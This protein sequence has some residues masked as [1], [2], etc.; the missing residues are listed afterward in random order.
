MTTQ[1][2]IP[3]SITMGILIITSCPS[4]QAEESIRL[5][6]KF[7]PGY[8]YH[9][10]TRTELAGTL[11]LP[12][13]KEQ[14]A[15]KTL[16]VTGSSSIEYDENVLTLESNGAVQKSARIYRRMDFQR[17][18]GDKLQQISLRPAVRRLIVLRNNHVEVPFSPDGPLTWGEIDLVRTD[19]FTPA[20]AGLLSEQP[21]KTG[22][23]WPVAKA[24]IRELTDLERIEEGSLE[25]RLDQITTLEKR[26]LARVVFAGSV[27]GINEDGPT[28]QQLD[29]YFFFDLESNHLSYLSLK[30]VHSLLD[31][32]GK[33]V[34]KIEGQFVLSRQAPQASKDLSE[35]AW[36]SVVVEPNAENTLLLYENEDLGVQFLHSR[37]WR[38]GGVQGRQITLD[39]S[40]GSGLM[41][42]VEPAA[43]I[44]TGAQYQAE[45][46]DWLQKQ[47][48][49]V[50]QMDPPKRIPGLAGEAEQFSVDLELKNQRAVMKYYVIPQKNAGATIAARLLPKDLAALQADVDKIVRSL[51]LAREVPGNP[52]K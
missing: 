17:K 1:C 52:K 41:I 48:A 18:V 49:K 7:H 46:R 27:R 32:D 25:C 14:A 37:R 16:S 42:T 12:K 21:V 15:P 38:V 19:V 5:Q 44:P 2:R 36:K 40:K 9:V 31:K 22:D 24:A 28:R 11:T 10:S 33:T 29:G 43:S 3:G 13:E 30:G 45:V 50:F 35:E 47:Q 8:Q 20:L 26:P 34:G 4:I 51:T 6:E 23:R 39:E